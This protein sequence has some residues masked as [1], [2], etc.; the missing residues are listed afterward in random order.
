MWKNTHVKENQENDKNF[1]QTKRQHPKLTKTHINLA[2]QDK[3]Q[4]R[5]I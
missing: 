2:D 4:L 1:V 5:S 3:Y